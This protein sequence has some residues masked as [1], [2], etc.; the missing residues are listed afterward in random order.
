MSLAGHSIVKY[1]RRFRIVSMEEKCDGYFLDAVRE[2]D[3]I[4]FTCF[5]KCVT[6]MVNYYLLNEGIWCV[7]IRVYSRNSNL[8]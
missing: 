7:F 1:V 4:R 5:L 2:G 3:F 8:T 6:T